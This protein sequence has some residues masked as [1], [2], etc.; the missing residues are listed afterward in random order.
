MD[1]EKTA[2]PYHAPAGGLPSQSDLHTGRAVFTEAYAFIPKGV[3]RDIVTSYLPFW[4]KTRAW[5]LSRPMTGFSETF[6]QYL[7]EVQP[8]GGS[9]RPELDEGA[10]GRQRIDGPD[11]QPVVDGGHRIGVRDRRLG[12]GHG[13]GWRGEC[14]VWADL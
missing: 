8:G 1:A 13:R 12:A 11:G 6:S 4:E 10:E 5:V 9:D 7:M 3:M 14:G 2:F